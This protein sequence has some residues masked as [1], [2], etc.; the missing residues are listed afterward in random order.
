MVVNLGGDDDGHMVL[1]RKSWQGCA[2][3]A[4][5]DD[6]RVKKVLA[7]LCHFRWR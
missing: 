5:D 7:E 4:S 2:N 3:L 6:G 1:T